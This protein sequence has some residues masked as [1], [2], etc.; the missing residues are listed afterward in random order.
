MK[1]K[2]MLVLLVLSFAL[3]PLVGQIF[4]EDPDPHRFD[5][6]MAVFVNWDN[7]NSVP[8]SAVLF[9]GSSSIRM[10]ETA[11]FFPQLKV[12]NRGFGGAH[13]SDVNFFFEKTVA[14]YK[15]GIILLYAGDND[16]AGQKPAQQVLRDFKTF[17]SKVAENQPNTPIIFIPIK[18]SIS[19]W[20]LWPVMK[21]ANEM[22]K[23][24]CETETRLFYADT[25]TPMLSGDGKPPVDLFIEDGLHMSEKGY[26]VW[27]K[28]LLPVIQQALKGTQIE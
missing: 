26:N 24:Y 16:V 15:A 20:Q 23:N 21:E 13:L 14:R 5:E 10:W 8:D 18:P 22:I 9:V 3:Q 2:T 11:I 19:R 6:E 1:I 17:C 7:K 28:V 4:V 27:T 12:I 25:A